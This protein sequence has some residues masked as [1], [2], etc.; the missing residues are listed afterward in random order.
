MKRKR[1]NVCD[2]PAR[3]VDLTQ[4]KTADRGLGVHRVANGVYQ[5]SSS[6]SIRV[7]IEFLDGE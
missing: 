4:V 5:E 2:H 1:H 6:R 7:A 3:V